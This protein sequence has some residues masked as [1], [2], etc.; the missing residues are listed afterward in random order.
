M[1]MLGN[2]VR[3]LLFLGIAGLVGWYNYEV[4]ALVGVITNACF[5]AL[6]ILLVSTWRR[7]EPE[8]SAA[9]QVVDA[10]EFFQRID[11]RIELY[12]EA[13]KSTPEEVVEG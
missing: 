5:L 12:L 4:N 8:T 1:R 6:G 2:L 13:E 11:E 7:A 10:D 9:V 3:S